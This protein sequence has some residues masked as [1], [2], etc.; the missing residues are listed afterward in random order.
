MRH[1]SPSPFLLSPVSRA[2]LCVVS[3][4][5]LG[6]GFHAPVHAQAMELQPPALPQQQEWTGTYDTETAPITLKMTPML[7]EKPP[8]GDEN[9]PPTFVFGDSVTGRPDLETVIDGNAE[10]RRGP[11]AIRADRIELTHPT[12]MLNAKGNVHVSS[13]GNQFRGPELQ[14]KL[15]TFEGYFAQPSY[16]FLSNGGNGKAGRIDFLSDKVLVA[17]NA[18]YTTCERDNEATWEPAW[19]LT[20]TSFKFDQETETGEA[21]GA[22]LRFKG[23]PIL[24]GPTISFPLSDKR[25]SGLLPPTYNVDSVSGVMWSQPYYLNIAPDMDATF[26]PTMMSKR[27]LD[28][29]SEFRYLNKT[30]SGR[31]RASYLVS[32]KLRNNIDRWSYA[33]THVGVFDTGTPTFGKL[34]LSLNLNRVSDN[35]YWKD[36]PR[37]STFLV[38]RLLSNDASVS[39]SKG[40]VST[41]V[42]ALTWQPLQDPLSV[43][44]PPYNRLPQITST[45]S[46]LNA[47]LAGA[48]GFDYSLSG[49]FTRFSADRALTRQPNSNRAVAIA[50]ISRP[51]VSP[52]WYFTPKMQLHSTM[53]RFDAPLAD[54]TFSKSRVVPTF[55]VD[56]GL[57]YE[58]KTSYFGRTFTQ[59]LEPRAFYVRTPYRDQSL[60]PNYDS[61]LN[62]FNFATVFTENAFVGNDRISDANLLTLGVT[63]RLLDPDTGAEKVRFGAAQRLRFADQRVTTPGGLPVTDRIS[64]LLF[65]TSINW[66]PQW[67][68]DATVQYN[69]KLKQSERSSYGVRYNPSHYRVISASLRYQ[70][71]I[72]NSVDVGW[73]WPLNDIWGDKGKDLGAGRGQGGGRLYTVGRLNYSIPERKLVDAIAG[74]EYDGCCWIG[75]VVLQRSQNTLVASN[76]RILFQLELVGFSR[77]GVNPLDTLKQNIPRY[78]FLRDQVT[79]P[80]RFTNYD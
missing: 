28:L 61:G 10:L 36:F 22:V 68:F 62:D 41:T 11:T 43:I 39:W 34:G 5:A 17:R 24:A 57:Q 78:E 58:R 2:V 15:D 52:G 42:S 73:Q 25:K 7:A 69:P 30:N 23:V 51:W 20:G 13:S 18:N 66:A 9:I 44:V 8:E 79:A 37:S 74:V 63:S 59:T 46:R 72:S 33:T 70:R 47:P 21:T 1:A 76:T 49:E 53:Y 19:T 60:L 54:G 29:G 27:G 56:S 26:S 32:D 50:Q 16:R 38:Q 40:Y 65:G 77:L 31:V 67:A 3:I 48:N 6:W 35:D 45:Y 80:S 71:N 64:D 14:L 12:D 75:R 4:T 55:S